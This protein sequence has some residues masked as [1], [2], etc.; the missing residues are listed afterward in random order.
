VDFIHGMVFS[1]PHSIIVQLK[2]IKTMS[3]KNVLIGFLSGIAAGAAIGILFAPA[4]GTDTRD[5]IKRTSRKVT[6]DITETIGKQVDSLRRHFNNFVDD[7]KN[8]FGNLE[9]E[10]KKKAT[11]ATKSAAELAEEKARQAKKTY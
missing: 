4:K 10:V 11:D 8:R 2:K 9:S 7:T 6:D 5:K 1:E 3:K